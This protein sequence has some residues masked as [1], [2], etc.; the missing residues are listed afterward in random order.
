TQ[1]TLASPI[2]DIQENDAGSF[3]R[4]FRPQNEE[5]SREFHAALRV[6]GRLVSV[7]DYLV[8]WIFRVDGEV[9]L[10][11]K[12]FVRANVSEALSVEHILATGNCHPSHFASSRARHEN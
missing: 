5:I 3:R 10:A 6:H 1:Q 4:I 12:L 2:W 9:H 7:S 11:G 8:V